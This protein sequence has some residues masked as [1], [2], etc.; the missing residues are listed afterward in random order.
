MPIRIL[1]SG[2]PQIP[3]RSALLGVTAVLLVVHVLLFAAAL[4]HV[5]EWRL[6]WFIMMIFEYPVLTFFRSRI[7]P[8]S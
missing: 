7:A 5:T 4:A 3:P 6:S 1:P 8:S 2:E